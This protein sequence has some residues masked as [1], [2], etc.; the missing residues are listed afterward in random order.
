MVRFEQCV[1]LSKD[2]H[3]FATVSCHLDRDRVHLIAQ[4]SPNQV[5]NCFGWDKVSGHKGNSSFLKKHGGCHSDDV[6]G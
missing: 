1:V 2:P 5:Y 4:R 6:C 3:P